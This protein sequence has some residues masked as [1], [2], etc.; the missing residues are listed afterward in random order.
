MWGIVCWI[1]L[2]VDEDEEGF[3]QVPSILLNHS[4]AL[5]YFRGNLSFAFFPPN[6]LKQFQ[7]GQQGSEIYKNFGER[8]SEERPT[9]SRKRKK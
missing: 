1:S 3:L 7:N 6:L 9:S 5:F 2:E 4:D 8:T